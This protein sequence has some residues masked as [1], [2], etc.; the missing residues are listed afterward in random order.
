MFYLAARVTATLVIGLMAVGCSASNGTYKD[1]PRFKAALEKP[2]VMNLL[3]SFYENLPKKFDKSRLKL[4]STKLM[5]LGTYSI[6]LGFEPGLIELSDSAEVRI[7]VKTDG[8]LSSLS[9]TDVR[10]S[11]FYFR[12][13]DNIANF[14]RSTLAHPRGNRVGVMCLRRD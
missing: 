8:S 6:P 3:E 5:G 4:A 13:N 10:G 9:I 11:M 14:K 2:A 1:C 7:D 12:V